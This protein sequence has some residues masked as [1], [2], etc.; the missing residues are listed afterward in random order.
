MKLPTLSSPLK[1]FSP[2]PAQPALGAAGIGGNMMF[3]SGG[4]GGDYDP[5]EFDQHDDFDEQPPEPERRPRAT[6]SSRASGS[7][8]DRGTT[9]G[10]P[11]TEQFQPEERYWT[12]YLRIA[13]PVIGLLLLIGLLWFWADRLIN[14]EPTPSEPV[15]T[16]N[17]GEVIT[18]TPTVP[19]ATE[20]AVTT[21]PANTAGGST[22][23]TPAAES[24]TGGD[25]QAGQ[26]QETDDNTQSEET[27]PSSEGTEDTFADGETVAVT[28]DVNLRPDPTTEGD[29]T[30]VLSAGD[31]LTITGGPEEGESYIWWEVLTSDGETTGW[32][33]E[34]FLEPAG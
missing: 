23:T 34:D 15:A 12:D 10:R 18:S 16:E 4:G 20:P 29:V 8:D 17:I 5:N 27:E 25:N 6:R 14:D 2:A 30:L 1:L 33:V 26:N 9:G 31:T 3:S 21:P 7:G 19:P 28:E 24:D 22:N 13:L 32:V 11:R